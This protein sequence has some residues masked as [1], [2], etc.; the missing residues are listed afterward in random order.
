MN[1][2]QP[3]SPVNLTK[4]EDVAY[5]SNKLMSEKDR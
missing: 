3:K 1:F 5:D 2:E 4:D